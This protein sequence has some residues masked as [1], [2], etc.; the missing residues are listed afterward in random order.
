[1]LFRGILIASAN[2]KQK[3]ID[4]QNQNMLLEEMEEFY[5]EDEGVVRFIPKD[6]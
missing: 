6:H 4:E 5:D 1:V 2:H 3:I